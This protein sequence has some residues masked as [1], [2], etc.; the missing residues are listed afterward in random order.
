MKFIIVGY[1]DSY[2]WNDFGTSVRDLQIAEILSRN[3]E[4]IF[5]NRPVSIYERILHK[6]KCNAVYKKYSERIKFI[7]TTSYDPFGPL[8]GRLWTEKCY[9]NIFDKVLKNHLQNRDGKK[10]IVI[11]FT[12]LA[13]LNY[14][15]D[16]NVYY[17]YDLIDNFQIQL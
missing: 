12:P 14:K 4:V 15:K 1:R 13:K 10:I 9:Q 5:I 11:D 2:F 6:K 17:W 3:Y 7:D 8:K 16:E